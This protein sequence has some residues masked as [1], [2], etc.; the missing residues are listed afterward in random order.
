M[1]K[2]NKSKRFTVKIPVGTVTHEYLSKNNKLSK[3]ELIEYAINQLPKSKE[4]R[5]IK[6]FDDFSR[7]LSEL[8]PD[9]K[10]S[11]EKLRPLVILKLVR[12][13]IGED[14][15]H[16]SLSDQYYQELKEL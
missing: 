7:S 10:K 14:G 4:E 3:W 15:D 1:G 8:Y 12:N 13:E 6:L 9:K 11:I 16:C 2:I 5:A